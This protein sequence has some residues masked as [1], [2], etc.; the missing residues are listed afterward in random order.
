[1]V[2]SSLVGGQR[3]PEGSF[4]DFMLR[5][6]DRKGEHSDIRLNYN[7][8]RED[9]EK[10]SKTQID[11]IA[12]MCSIIQNFCSIYVGQT[13]HL[14]MLFH[15]ALNMCLYIEEFRVEGRILHT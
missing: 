7:R 4:N 13:S 10:T 9:Y 12:N 2:C 5:S 14:K 1:M 3:K 6:R 11:G 15:L 8:L